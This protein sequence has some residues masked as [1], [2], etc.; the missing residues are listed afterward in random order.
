MTDGL[1]KPLPYH[2]A[3]Q[4]RKGI[5]AGRYAPGT[6]LREEALEAEYGSSRGP[7]REALRLLELRGLVSHLPR[8]GFRVREYSAKTASELYQLRSLLE[9][10]AVEQL[11]GRDLA[12][13]IIELEGCNARMLQKREAGDVEGYL[14]ENV[15]FHACILEY[16]GNEALTRTLAVLNEMA[17]PLRYAMLQRNLSRSRSVDDHRRIVGL[18]KKGRIADAALATE[19][20]ISDNLPKLLHELRL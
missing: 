17:E 5:I 10:F 13:V 9:R 19:R 20:H 12:P 16:L 2:L 7:V 6:S 1:P 18:L 4:I 15:N 14:Q 3:A 8:R 11:Q